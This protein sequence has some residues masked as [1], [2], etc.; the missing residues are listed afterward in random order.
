MDSFGYE[1]DAV[2]TVAYIGIC[3]YCGAG[4]FQIYVNSKPVAI[5]S[6]GEIRDVA[7]ESFDVVEHITTGPTVD[8][9]P[10]VAC[11]DYLYETR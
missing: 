11:D 8:Y 5:I 6:S 10:D 7:R 2:P 1:G 4:E 9:Q 3:C